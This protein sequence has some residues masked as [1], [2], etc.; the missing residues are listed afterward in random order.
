MS[1]RNLNQPESG[2]DE[3]KLSEIV[4]T[5]NEED[6]L[7]EPLSFRSSLAKVM[8]S[9]SDC[10]NENLVAVRYGTYST[11]VLLG[12]YS[13]SQ[14]PL[15][16]HYR[17]L[18]QIPLSFIRRR[19]ILNCRLVQAH[20][21]NTNCLKCYV[22]HLSPMETLLSRAQFETWT[23]FD[24]S[25]ITSE[26]E[27]TDLLCLHLF[28]VRNCDEFSNTNYIQS[29]AHKRTFVRCQL[30]FTNEKFAIARLYIYSFNRFM[31]IP[32]KVDLGAELV[33]MGQVRFDNTP[34]P[35]LGKSANLCTNGQKEK[36]SDIRYF[37]HLSK[38]E[39]DAILHS[40]GM[41][42]SPE[43]RNIE[44]ELVEKVEWERKAKWYQKLWKRVWQ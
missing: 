35:L 24:P 9:F 37:N 32:H 44:S 33:K 43:L 28:G 4:T 22:R 38:S 11:V 34:M 19:K 40:R 36:Q 21:S 8:N 17:T 13:L 14:T 2:K 7:S 25:R 23:Q 1:I 18:Q 10:V 20:P 15:F 26:N 6:G 39:H 42:K 30:L 5:A 31:F 16:F 41:W 12:A 29:L 27:K 3:S